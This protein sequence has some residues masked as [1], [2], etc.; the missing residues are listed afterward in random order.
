MVINISIPK[1]IQNEISKY[2]TNTIYVIL[3]Y[4]FICIDHS[5][6][7]KNQTGK[8]DKRKKKLNN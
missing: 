1:I 8:M 3:D 4:V 5:I 2:I 7:K 6:T